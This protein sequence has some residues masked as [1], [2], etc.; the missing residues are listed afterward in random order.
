[1]KKGKAGFCKAKKLLQNLI[2]DMSVTFDTKARKKYGRAV[3]NVKTKNK[4]VNN[5][6]GKFKK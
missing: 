5:K 1:M 3:A 2:Q 4:S 6:M